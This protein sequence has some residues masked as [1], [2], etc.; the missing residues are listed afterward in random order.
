[1]KKILLFLFNVYLLNNAYAAHY[2]E[3]IRG[4][5]HERQ[6]MNQA[7]FL[8]VE[9]DDLEQL[10]IELYSAVDWQNQTPSLTMNCEKEFPTSFDQSHY[11]CFD[12]SAFE[13]AVIRLSIKTDRDQSQL[14]RTYLKQIYELDY[15]SSRYN[16][17][18]LNDEK[19]LFYCRQY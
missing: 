5:N 19:F 15:S 16:W 3:L 10:K 13:N 4:N 2:C 9:H 18:L 6:R 7:E 14:N 1:M 17:R 11:L 8:K 12:G